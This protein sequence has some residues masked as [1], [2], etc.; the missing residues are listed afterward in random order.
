[1]I[2]TLKYGIEILLTAI[3]TENL[4][5][6]RAKT[7]VSRALIQPRVDKIVNFLLTRYTY[8]LTPAKRSFAVERRRDFQ[9]RML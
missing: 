1:M 8:V 5:N 9:C 2:S 7:T 4:N 6:L 3:F